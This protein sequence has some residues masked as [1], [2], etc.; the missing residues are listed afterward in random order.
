MRNRNRMRQRP[1]ATRQQPQAA[2]PATPPAQPQPVPVDV[3]QLDRTIFVWLGNLTIVTAFIVLTAMGIEYVTFLSFGGSVI[4]MCYFCIIVIFFCGGYKMFLAP[5]REFVAG[6]LVNRWFGPKAPKTDAESLEFKPTAFLE[7]VGSTVWN[8]KFPWQSVI[9]INLN[10]HEPMGKADEA[11]SSDGVKVTYNWFGTLRAVRGF[12][13]ALV[14]IGIPAAIS[15]M[16]KATGVAMAQNMN[17]H[18]HRELSRNQAE[19]GQEVSLLYGGDG[20]MSTTELRCRLAAEGLGYENLKRSDGLQTSAELPERTKNLQRAVNLLMKTQKGHPGDKS[21]T[22][23][24]ATD[25]ILAQ[26]KVAELIV[27]EGLDGGSG[28]S[29]YYEVNRRG[30]RGNRGNQQND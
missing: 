2:Q 22:R 29:K 30:N 23:L 27:N 9:Y 26:E 12:C 28:I 7:E 13:C 8:P 20:H 6:V 5:V 25:R 10:R 1:A 4:I 21:L 16:T 17:H 18:T 24:K 11:Y 14:R 19:I 3:R 15:I